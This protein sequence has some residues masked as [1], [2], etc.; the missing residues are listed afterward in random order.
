MPPLL[1]ILTNFR[2]QL[3]ETKRF[4]HVVIAASRARLLFFATERIRSDGNDWN[5]AQRWIGFNSAC[6]RVAIHDWQLDIHQDEIGPLLCYRGKRLLAVFDF[7]NLIA[8]GA[9]YRG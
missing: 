2:E 8:A 1:Q 5:R 9:A 7:G 4:R 6:G 3:T